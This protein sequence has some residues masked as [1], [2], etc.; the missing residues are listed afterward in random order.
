MPGRGGL[1]AADELPRRVQ[2]AQVDA[3]HEDA[4]PRRIIPALEQRDHGAL[5]AAGGP[6]RA[7]PHRDVG[8]A[9]APPEAPRRA[10][11]PPHRN[12]EGDGAGKMEEA[13]ACFCLQQK[14][15]L[16]REEK[17]DIVDDRVRERF[18]SRRQHPL[19]R[20]RTV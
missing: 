6:G 8:D 16:V 13:Y 5:A 14:R 3:I 10:V 11:G 20:H 2:A 18:L 15:E 17:R 9:P 4:P 12:G 19:S 7:G 1:L